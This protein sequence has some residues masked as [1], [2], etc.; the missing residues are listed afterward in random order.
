MKSIHPSRFA[1]LLRALATLVCLFAA[2]AAHAQHYVNGCA[3]VGGTIATNFTSA[4]P[5]TSMTLTVGRDVPNG[6]VL[7]RYYVTG[8]AAKIECS[9]S[10][11]RTSYNPNWITSTQRKSSWNQGIYGGKTWETGVPGIGVA[12]QLPDDRTVLPY[13]A[14]YNCGPT[15]TH[16]SP[17][18]K[19]QLVLIKTGPVSPGWIQSSALPT[20]GSNWWRDPFSM[21]PDDSGLSVT[22]VKFSGS[23]HILA[24][25]CRT[26][27]VNVDMGNELTNTFRGKGS[28]SRWRAFSVRL[29]D[30][31]RF[32]R[33][34]IVAVSD[35]KSPSA[36]PTTWIEST[37]PNQ[38]GVVLTPTTAILDQAAGVV[39]LSPGTPDQPSATGVG[40]QLSTTGAGAGTPVQYDTVMPTG[41]TPTIVD[42]A[43]YQFDLFARYYQ[44][45]DAITPGQANS[46]VMFTI[47]YR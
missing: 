32:Y 8:P 34:Q 38:L 2:H 21:L 40:L 16:T 43:T 25:T 23:I 29:E 42:D 13:R 35:F 45:G 14:E 4:I 3:L 5:T 20:V 9:M 12:V 15:C 7:Y 22:R 27:D 10:L 47:D 30:C 28:G 44:T 31:P 1:G 26:P 17:T 11:T 19:F 46:A 6:T 39:A 36:D 41:I 18:G 37:T 24:R 33:S